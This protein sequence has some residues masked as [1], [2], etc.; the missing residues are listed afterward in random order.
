M[1]HPSCRQRPQSSRRVRRQL[2]RAAR[3]TA[4]EAAEAL[5]PLLN[6]MLGEILSKYWGEHSDMHTKCF[7]NLLA[8]IITIVAC[9]QDA[10][11]SDMHGAFASHSEWHPCPL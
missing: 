1:L 5:H 10:N 8:L 9:R 11:C 2:A 6:S 4:G 3:H 7:Q